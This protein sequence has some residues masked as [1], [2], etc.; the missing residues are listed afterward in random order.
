M[1]EGENKNEVSESK[2]WGEKTDRIAVYKNEK[3]TK[4]RKHRETRAVE[5]NKKKK[6]YRCHMNTTTENKRNDFDRKKSDG[7]EVKKLENPEIQGKKGSGYDEKKKRIN[8]RK[9]EKQARKNN[10]ETHRL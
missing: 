3:P 5:S 9:E 7:K 1:S 4:E 8:K 10:R 2:N 6:A